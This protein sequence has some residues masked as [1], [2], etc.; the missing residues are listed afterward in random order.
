[1]RLGE[2][3]APGRKV[4]AGPQPGHQNS[5][6]PALPPWEVPTLSPHPASRR[7]EGRGPTWTEVP[8]GCVGGTGE[9]RGPRLGRVHTA[10]GPLALVSE[11][12]HPPLCPSQSK[13]RRH[14]LEWRHPPAHVSDLGQRQVALCGPGEPSA[15]GECWA[16]ELTQQKPRRGIP[17]RICP[18]VSCSKVTGNLRLGGE[19]GSR[20]GLREG[21]AQ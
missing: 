19:E 1:M 13:Q 7:V 10:G 14:S 17:G 16:R 8:S 15:H 11:L 3:R 18:G 6:P 21:R 2:G 5:H 4:P 9:P 12:T 20:E